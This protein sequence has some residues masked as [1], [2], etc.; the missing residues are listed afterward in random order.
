MRNFKVDPVTGDLAKAGGNFVVV[1]DVAPANLA[2][3]AQMINTGLQTNTGEIYQDPDLGLPITDILVR[4]DIDLD[5]KNSIIKE[6]VRSFA[7]VKDITKYETS[8]IGEDHEREL[9]ID[10][11][12]RSDQGVF[13]VQVN[14]GEV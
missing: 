13:P 5:F 7:F 2:A 6:Y 3:M 8:Y 14:V 12:I 9:V 4:K 11:E 10:M 1:E